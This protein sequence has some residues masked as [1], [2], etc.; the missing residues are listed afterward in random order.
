MHRVGPNILGEGEAPAAAN[1]ASAA[2]GG[3]APAADGAAADAAPGGEAER[4]DGVQA[5]IA[6]G[7]DSVTHLLNGFPMSGT[8]HGPTQV[9][10]LYST[11]T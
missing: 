3:A 7:A 8:D 2:D 5:I 6:L 10:N 11:P 9:R 4:A 1:G